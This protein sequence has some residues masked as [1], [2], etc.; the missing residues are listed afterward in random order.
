MWVCLYGELAVL[1]VR[2]VARL[3]HSDLQYCGFRDLFS[4]PRSVLESFSFCCLCEKLPDTAWKGSLVAVLEDTQR[5]VR[6]C[7]QSCLSADA[8]LRGGWL[9]AELLELQPGTGRCVGPLLFR[10]G[11]TVDFFQGSIYS[12]IISTIWSILQ[13]YFVLNGRGLLFCVFNWVVQFAILCPHPP[14]REVWGLFL[15]FFLE[16]P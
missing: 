12:W 14:V 2:E 3:T 15:P 10:T 5:S 11:F 16:P 13:E 6:F 1:S 7:K 9:W 4:L 8:L